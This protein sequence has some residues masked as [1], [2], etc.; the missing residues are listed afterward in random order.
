MH[1]LLAVREIAQRRECRVTAQG[2]PA[3]G[4]QEDL[5]RYALAARLTHPVQ[6]ALQRPRSAPVVV[7][8]GEPVPVRVPYDPMAL[9]LQA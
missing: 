3:S 8:R 2:L 7:L 6:V 5:P 4:A 9:A 1:S